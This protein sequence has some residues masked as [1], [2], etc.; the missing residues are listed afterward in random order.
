MELTSLHLLLTYKCTLACDH[1]FVWG[2]PYQDGTMTLE[3]LSTILEQAGDLETVESIYFEGGEP[4][5]CYPVLVEGVRQA[6][7]LGFQTGIVSNGYWANSV[8]VAV[9][10]LAPIAGQL[11]VL[12][13][14]SDLYHWDEKFKHNYRNA[15]AAAQELGIPCDVIEIDSPEAG[16]AEAPLGQLPPG[17]SGVMYRGRAAEKLVG[18][19]SLHPWEQFTRCPYEDL[20]EPG[21]VHLDPLGYVHLCQGISMG[22]VFQIPLAEIF[23]TYDPESHPVAGPLLRGGPA[24]LCRAYGLSPDSCYADACHLCYSS[25]EMLRSQ[26]PEILAPDQVYGQLMRLSGAALQMSY[27]G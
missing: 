7:R 8:E 5:L 23:E 11:G 4:F 21:R 27:G 18:G 25:R 15:L 24:E 22:N 1:C 17:V 19:D 14:S 9:R 20:R 2:S 16:I 26:L 13:V 10:K 12:I 3:A 6:A